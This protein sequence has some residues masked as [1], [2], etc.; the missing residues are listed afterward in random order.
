MSKASYQAH[1]EIKPKKP[2]MEQ[3]VHSYLKNKGATTLEMIGFQLGIKAQ[4]ASA[5]LSEMHDKGIV[6][7][8]PYGAYRLTY[9]EE[10]K[11]QTILIRGREKRDKWIAQGYKNKWIKQIYAQVPQGGGHTEVRMIFTDK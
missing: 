8:D 11:Q 7:F 3:Q 5:R 6:T 2:S 4:T 10:E 9:D 1:E